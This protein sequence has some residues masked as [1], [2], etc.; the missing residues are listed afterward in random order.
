MLNLEIK[1]FGGMNVNESEEALYAKAYKTNESG[2]VQV[3]DFE[4]PEIINMDYDI[5]GIIRRSGSVKESSITLGVDDEV[6]E[7][8]KWTNA[9]GNLAEFI[10]TLQTLY[11][12]INGGAW[13]VIDDH[14]V[15]HAHAI[16]KCT[17]TELDGHLFIGFNG[18]EFIHVYRTGTALDDELSTCETTVDA[19]SN[20]G[21]PVLNV[22]STVCFE[23]GEL[24]DVDAGD[25]YTI[26]SIQAGVSLTMTTDLIATYG[27]PDAVF[28]VAL[29][30]DANDPTIT[31]QMTGVWPTDAYLTEA[32]NTRLAFS[33]GN[34]YAE[35]TPLAMTASSGIW[36]L[37]NGGFFPVSSNIISMFA[38]VPETSNTLNETLYFGT[39]TGFELTTGFTVA[40]PLFKIEGSASPVN[41]RAW[42]K[43]GS[44]VCYLDDQNNIKGINGTRII[45]LGRRLNSI[46]TDNPSILDDA[47]VTDT[48]VMYD[49]KKK[50]ICVFFS[51]NKINDYCAVIDFTRGEPVFNEPQSSYE[52]RVRNLL[53]FVDAD[54]FVAQMGDLTV[55]QDAVVYNIN[56][57]KI[58]F[59]DGTTGDQINATWK[60]PLFNAGLI[61][62]IKQFYSM[63]LRVIG[64]SEGVFTGILD[65]GN[66]FSTF[67]D[68]VDGGAANTV[69]ADVLQGG[70]AA[71]GQVIATLVT[72]Y[73]ETD[74][75]DTYNFDDPVVPKGTS[76]IPFTL[77]RKGD[78]FRL[79]I[80]SS[81]QGETVIYK[82]ILMRFDIGAELR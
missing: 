12:R 39:E 59:F 47:D 65:G 7:T 51:V 14:G 69:F 53:W 50:H 10:A 24:V 27:S 22:A 64:E 74:D 63:D 31:N 61:S 60:S 46:D 54:W 4:S 19:N 77:D 71:M 15:P 56:S 72:Q 1:R 40:D 21:Q 29:Y 73:D 58:D 16:T 35:Y 6:V 68:V 34:H 9:D 76:V 5:R 42:A 8:H 82:S 23:V 13:G 26:L 18:G 38:F 33:T 79:S 2:F 80:N 48:F 66:A 70:T 20:I 49:S 28:K 25:Q 45:N 44:W 57:G 17:F 3:A 37:E 43:S 67:V 52:L 78:D 55:T 11:I 32:V 41:Y 75:T 36:D 30:I 62:R 81:F